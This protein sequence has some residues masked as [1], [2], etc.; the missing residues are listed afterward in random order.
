MNEIPVEVEVRQ[1]DINALINQD[2]GVR[3]KLQSLSFQRT[4]KEQAAEIRRLNEQIS[5]MEGE[6]DA[7]SG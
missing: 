3:M 5:G 1:E 4:I 2:I 6:D 7:E